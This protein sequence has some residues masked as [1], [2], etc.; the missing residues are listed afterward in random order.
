MTWV[1]EVGKAGVLGEMLREQRVREDPVAVLRR[2]AVDLV[3]RVCLIPQLVFELGLGLR[4][5]LAQAL[6]LVGSRLRDGE[7]EG[8][9][10]RVDHH[11]LGEEH[12]LRVVDAVADHRPEV[13]GVGE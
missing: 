6:Q 3:V 5:L 4:E 7:R 9:T 11:V 1:D 13:V 10:R 8:S 2:P 12:E